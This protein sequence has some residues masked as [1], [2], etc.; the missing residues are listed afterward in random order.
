MRDTAQFAVA[1]DGLR[2]KSELFGLKKPEI[3]LAL[4]HW[5]HNRN[6]GR[7]IQK[8]DEP[9]QRIGQCGRDSGDR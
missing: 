4:N 3:D 9:K 8:F 6:V 2:K 5:S 1:Y 7:S